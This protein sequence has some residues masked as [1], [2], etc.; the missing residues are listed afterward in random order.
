MYLHVMLFI[1]YVNELFLLICPVQSW[2][3]EEGDDNRLCFE[4]SND[5]VSLNSILACGLINHKKC[6]ITLIPNYSMLETLI[7]Q[8]SIAIAH[9]FA[10]VACEAPL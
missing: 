8:C 3:K 2:I 6:V 9:K 5:S 4:S 1:F 10:S 7:S